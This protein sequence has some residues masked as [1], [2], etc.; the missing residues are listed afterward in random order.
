[1]SAGLIALLAGPVILIPLACYTLAHRRVR[2]ATWYGVLL[3]T[4]AFWSVA[5]AWELLLPDRE[6]KILALKAKYLG[7]VLLPSSWIGFILSFVGFQPPRVWSR[8]LPVALVSA[9]MLVLAWTDEWHGLF[10]G[11]NR[12]YVV[13]GYSV[14]QGRGPLFWVN[15][16]YTYFVL[17]TGIVLLAL[18][19]A[20]SPYLYRRSARILILGAVVPWLGNLFFVMRPQETTVDPTPFLFSCSAVIAALAVF[21]YE[22]LEPG[23]T[24]RDA[25]IETVGDGII[26]LDR[27]QRIADVNPAAEAFLGCSRAEAAGKPVDLLVP[28][29]PA[30]PVDGTAVDITIDARPGQAHTYDV[31]ASDVRSRAGELTGSVVVLRDVTEQRRAERAL[32]ESELLYR[33]VIELASDGLWVADGAGTIV[34]VNPGACAMLGYER[35]ELVDRALSD[36]VDREQLNGTPLDD[37]RSPRGSIDWRGRVVAKDGR[38]L[39]LAGRSTAITPDLVVST[40]RD[41]TEERAETERRERLLL[42]AQAAI[43][44]KDEFL[45][46]LSHELRTPIAAVLGWTRM[47]ARREVEPERVAHAL[48]V[49][50]RNAQAQARLV[51]DLLDVSQMARGRLHLALAETEL[52]ALLREALDAIGPSADAKGVSIDVALPAS[53]RRVWVDPGRIQQVLWNLFTNAIKFTPPGGSVTVSCVDTPDAVELVVRDTG[54]G[55][56]PDFLP[57]VFE[58]FR[59]GEVRRSRGTAGLGLGL[60]I[61]RRIV[62]AHGGH[63]EAASEGAGKGT[64]VRVQ[65]PSAASSRRRRRAADHD[66]S[67]IHRD[68]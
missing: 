58:P 36:L 13:N 40:F 44:L 23:P 27:R 8:V 61:V 60:A 6:A 45:A 22:L 3:L 38:R 31:R 24:L 32:R 34:D 53:V 29:W 43:R 66:T 17:A 19:A 49:I 25:R 68:A 50:E 16:A 11:P 20:H 39:L 15:V 67:P 65:L 51:D 56:D 55:I 9:V 7:V 62:D 4:I 33:T 52:P 2:G 54:Q 63:V 26:I 5:Y 12:L 10:W 64:T 30:D 48:E 42:D 41:I 21:R 18:H 47:L 59:Q 1:M 46:T 37:E 28:Q 35:A 57:F 14:L